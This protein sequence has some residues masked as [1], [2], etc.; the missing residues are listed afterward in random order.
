MRALGYDGQLTANNELGRLEKM[1]DKLVHV[2][3]LM[4][5]TC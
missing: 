4:L 5:S 1:K 2:K 3:Y